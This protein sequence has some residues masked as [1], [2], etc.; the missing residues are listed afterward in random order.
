MK[1]VSSLQLATSGA[2]QSSVL[3]TV[4]FNILISDINEKT[5]C[6]PSRFT[7]DTKLGES[8]DLLEGRKALQRDL[9]RLH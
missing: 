9:H 3:G 6:T 2:S 1:L 7:F 8:A 4:V 5:E